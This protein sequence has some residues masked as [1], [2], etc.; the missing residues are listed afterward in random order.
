[1]PWHQRLTAMAHGIRATAARH[2][3]VFPLLLSRPAR[4][5]EALG[6]RESVYA[7]LREAGLDPAQVERTE[8]LVSTAILGFAASEAAGRFAHHPAPVR[9]TDFAYLLDWLRRIIE[10]SR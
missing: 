5:G 2:P 7:A 1:M 9:D 3:G 6:V 8:R 4:T 10:G